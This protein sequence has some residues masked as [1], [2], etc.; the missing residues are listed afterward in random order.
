VCRA[1]SGGNADTF[2]EGA[3]YGI[4]Q[5]AETYSPYSPFTAPSGSSVYSKFNADEI[6]FK[7]K[8]LAESSKRVAKV[9]KYIEKKQWEE[10]RSELERQVYSMRGTMNYL[11]SGKAEA[12][13]KA[14]EFYQAMEAVNLYAK[15]KKQPEAAAAYTSMMSAL[16]AYSK[17]I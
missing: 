1:L 7:K 8:L 10:V 6:A 2:S 5:S 17:L 15:Q 4:D 13:A 16:T 12:A 9:D 11:A 3:A 14:T